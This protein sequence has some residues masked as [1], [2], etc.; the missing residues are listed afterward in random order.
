MSRWQVG[1]DVGGTF[2][3]VVLVDPTSGTFRIAKVP[4]TPAD[5]SEGVMGGL[6]QAAADLPEMTAF[7]HGTTVGTN[8]VLERKGAVCGL[9]TTAGFR[10]TLE[11]GRRT[12]PN[13]YGMTGTFEPL[14]SR[15]FRI[16]V[17]ERV[18][19]AGRVLI[20]LDEVAFES[21][22]RA[23]IERGAEALVIHFM[24]SYIN[25][26]QELR[27]AEIARKI[28]P[29]SY[30]TVGHEVLREAREFERAS[31]AAVNASIQPIMA[32]YL[33]RLAGKLGDDGFEPEP[34]VMQ[35]NA[36]TMT[37]RAA[38]EHAVQTVMSGPA[39]GVLAAARVGVEAGIGSIIACDMGGTSFDVTLIRDGSPSLSAEKDM[40]YAVPVR[41]P[42]IDVHTIGAGG[43]SIARISR[44][45]LLQVGP[46]SAGSR[47]G[48][49][50]YGRGGTLPTVTDANL[51]L[52]RL[53]PASMPGIERAVP[54]AAVREAILEHVGRPLGMDAVQA[55]TAII[56]VA[57][58]HLA[59][60]IRLVSIERGYDPRDFALFAFGGAGPLHATA[61]AKELGVPRVLV[62]RFPGATSALGCILA[63]LR[64][65][66]VQTINS[67]L[68]ESD[69][70]A[71]DAI[72]AEQAARG[73]A[74][75][76][77]ERVPVD[78]IVVVHE[79]DLLFRGQ[80]H[81]FR[82]PVISPGFDPALVMRDFAARY[83]ARFNIELAEMRVILVNLRTCV[84]G[85]RPK[86]SMELFAPAPSS[87]SPAG[88]HAV[89]SVHFSGRFYE[90][91]I[92]RRESLTVGS[93]LDGPVIVEQMDA[94]TVVDPGARLQVDRLGNLIISV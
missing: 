53:D 32:R 65:D 38:A 69:G 52:G 25:P 17:P 89:R 27:A 2:T 61:L 48:P 45:G 40:A 74:I 3:D 73:R 71:F 76:E 64:H 79:A 56:S 94:T 47:P 75:V 83:R 39:A 16:E 28:W 26:R 33:G 13:P 15:E 23:L 59:S 82:M 44:A 88:P 92:W 90:T 57:T 12:R 50:C 10:D 24:H 34:L 91:P 36:G 37:M 86:I 84:V 63:D 54:V 18:D 8:A 62:P 60:A 78:G 6:R 22:V 77:R 85:T 72:L 29:N 5:Q 46:E 51:L 42:M 19:A 9:V 67:P 55:S 20:P 11:L 66:F 14:I 49:I 4:S 68:A 80:S 43:G 81:V 70:A 58:N 1:V 87:G 41:V 31:T 35:G 30:V 21:A 7:V 93:T